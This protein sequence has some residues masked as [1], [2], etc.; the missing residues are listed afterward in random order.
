M[1]EETTAK[2]DT[3]VATIFAATL[4]HDIL[5]AILG[6]LRT[7]PDHWLRMNED[8]QQKAISRIRDK[9][10][11]MVH[12]TAQILMRGEFPAVPCEID[13]IK[14]TKDVQISLTM[15]PGAA[16]R[17]ALYDAKGR[18]VLLVLSDTDRWLD[19]MEEVKAKADQLQLFDDDYDPS[20]DQPAYRRD[21]D[22]LAPAA[23]TWADL[24]KNLG[25]KPEQGMPAD[26]GQLIDITNLTDTA[27]VY[28]YNGFEE[29]TLQRMR[30]DGELEP[31]KLRDIQRGDVVEING[32]MFTTTAPALKS[33]EGFYAITVTRV[34]PIAFGKAAEEQA[35]KNDE[36]SEL[37]ILLEKLW[38]V[39]V[40]LSLGTL[41]T[42]TPQQ[43]AVTTEWVN[44]YAADPEHCKIARP[45]FLPMPDGGAGDDQQKAAEG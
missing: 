26:A 41:Q 12:E 4:G 13:G 21:Q 14:I 7:M 38:A 2:A 31:A 15:E 28:R 25:A 6:E 37:Q 35:Q 40:T 27:N 22:A 32:E 10:R 9:V 23:P 16:M 34:E 8:N 43:L 3:H 42:F 18:H 17:H 11:T 33:G 5:A 24:K 29:S 45:F 30:G 1:T 36:R 19:R 39:H 44:A 20:V